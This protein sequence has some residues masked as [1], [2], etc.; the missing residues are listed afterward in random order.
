LTKTIEVRAGA[1]AV[2]VG[3]ALRASRLLAAAFA[4]RWNLTLTGPAGGRYARTEEGAAGS[5]EESGE[6]EGTRLE[7]VD[8]WLG[9]TARLEWRPRA[10][11]TWAP[12]YTVSLSEAGLERVWQGVEVVMQWPLALGPEP[13]SGRIDLTLLPHPNRR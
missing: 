13:W 6:R 11:V 2:G 12:V 3:Y 8:D 7:L 1:D 10:R 9:L 5:L 4:V